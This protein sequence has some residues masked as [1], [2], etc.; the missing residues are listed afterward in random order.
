MEKKFSALSHW[1]VTRDLLL[2]RSFWCWFAPAEKPRP[3]KPRE[4][5]VPPG[6]G[7][8]PPP[9]AAASFA[10]GGGTEERERERERENP[11][12][13]R[14]GAT[15]ISEQRLGFCGPRSRYWSF[16]I[17]CFEKL[18]EQ[19]GL[20]NLSY[21]SAKMPKLAPP[22]LSPP[23]LAPPARFWLR[24]SQMVCFNEQQRAT[25]LWEDT[26]W[27]CSAP[28]HRVR[29]LRVARL[30]EC[31]LR[32]REVVGLREGSQVLRNLACSILFRP[33]RRGRPTA[34]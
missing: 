7:T 4:R 20:W 19:L 25:Q 23:K 12:G 11:H 33:A 13:G 30:R 27:L 5:G 16:A 9:A 10:G 2:S 3:R 28:P 22:K 34:M 32:I 24:Y 6:H 8:L 21:E 14:A 26:L 17:L 29:A 15:G 1:H 31:R 18:A